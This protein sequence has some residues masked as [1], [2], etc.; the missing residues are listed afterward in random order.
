MDV[1]QARRAEALKVLEAAGVRLC[2]EVPAARAVAIKVG[3]D[4]CD[5]LIL[6]IWKTLG[7]VPDA[8]GYIEDGCLLTFMRDPNCLPC[9]SKWRDYA[10]E[11]REELGV[12]W[13]RKWRKGQADELLV[14]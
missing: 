4:L 12:N 3:M 7:K 6:E 14:D 10:A 11:K 9:G 13:Q 1:I 2:Y 8:I 5:P